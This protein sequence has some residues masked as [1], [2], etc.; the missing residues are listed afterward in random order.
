[1]T[2]ENKPEWL[3]NFVRNYEALS[4]DN[5]D[6]IRVI[7]H[8]EVQFQD[9]AH[10]LSGL[11]TLEQYFTSLYT[12]LSACT[13]TIDS[14]V[15]EGDKAAIYWT[16]VFCHPKLNRGRQVT[17]EGS[18]LIQGRE[19]KVIYHRDYLDMGGMLYEHIPV[20]GSLVRLVKKR[21]SQ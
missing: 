10:Q 11:D 14:T 1:M 9:P 3:Q 21:L 17:V 7:Y 2:Q 16:M 12:N 8:R 18:S 20:L 6:L 19:N 15:V 5:L 13:F 4:V